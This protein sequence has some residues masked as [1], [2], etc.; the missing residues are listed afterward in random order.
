MVAPTCFGIT[1]T[2]SGSVPS[3]FWE[4][5][6]WGAVH[7]ILWMGV[8]CPV[9]RCVAISDVEAIILHICRIWFGALPSTVQTSFEAH[10]ASYSVGTVVFFR[11]VN[12]P[13][14][15]IQCR[16]YEWVELYLCS[17]YMPS[18]RGQGQL[19]VLSKPR[20]QNLSLVLPQSLSLIRRC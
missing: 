9:T 15:A 18:W 12:R 13:G 16:G 4:M 14:L 11:R 10:S 6:N 2:S 5:L 17:P 20:S 19:H 7:R 1:L 3:A 8:L